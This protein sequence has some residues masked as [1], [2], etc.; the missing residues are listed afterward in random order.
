M[1]FIFWKAHICYF[2][3]QPIWLFLYCELNLTHSWFEILNPLYFFKAD[4]QSMGLAVDW[5]R[6]FI[7][8]DVNPFYDSF[9]KWQFV[10][11][12]NRDKVKF[13]KR[14]TIFR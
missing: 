3:P 4:L 13:G 5:R 10:H 11:L 14:Y 8:T 12:K 9:V 6:A 1:I 7:T 2:V